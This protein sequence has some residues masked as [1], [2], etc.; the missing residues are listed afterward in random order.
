VLFV[1][2][3]GTTLVEA[4][5]SG[6]VFQVARV[7]HS[8]GVAGGVVVCKR[9]LPR[10]REEPAAR[11]ALVREAKALGRARHPAL[12][13]LL[14]VG[15]DGHGPFVIES[16][17]PGI[18]VRA[19][20]EGW[21]ARRCE[22]PPR[23]VTHLAVAAAEALAEVHALS[24]AGGPVGLS[25]GDLGP[26]HVILTPLGA[27]GLVDFGA[28]RFAGMDASLETADRGTLPFVAPEVAR[29]EV[30]PD[31]AADVYALAATLLFLASGEPLLPPRDDA[32]LLLEV[33]EHGLPPDLCDRALGL[34]PTGRDALREALAFAPAH[35]QRSARALAA[36][37]SR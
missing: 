31:Q 16:D 4:L 22:V 5:P 9:L 17:I 26:D 25:H 28:A 15:N 23:L 3:A 21:H 11:A 14:D 32:A 13:T 7:R 18:S 29:G 19:L 24:G 10:V 37:L 34:S 30:A 35:R 27:V 2:P 6:S 8:G 36:A 12:P 20:V 33:G 1:A